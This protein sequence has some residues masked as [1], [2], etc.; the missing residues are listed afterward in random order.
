MNKLWNIGHEAAYHAWLAALA[1]LSCLVFT[2]LSRSD[3]YTVGPGQQ[4]AEPHQIPLLQPGDTVRIIGR[5][6]AN[7]YRS[8]LQ[9]P[10]NDVKILC[11]DG[12]NGRCVFD[13][14]DA[15]EAP[16]VKYWSTQ[17]T[18]QG[19]FTITPSANGQKVKGVTISG[20]KIIG[21]RNAGAGFTDAAG[22]KRGWNF[23]AAGIA[24]YKCADVTITGCAIHDND[25]GIFGTSNAGWGEDGIIRNVT[26][27]WTNF[28]RN[29]V[30]GSD[31]YHNSYI[32]GVNTTYQLCHY[33]PPI[34]GSAGCNLK[35]R[36]AS[37]KIRYC[38]IEGG[39]R[40][41]DLVDPEEGANII[42]QDPLFGRDYVYGNLIINPASGGSATMIHFGFDGLAQNARQKLFYAYNTLVH[43]WPK[44]GATWYAYAFKTN[45]SQEIYAANSIFHGF[46]TDGQ[47][48]SEFRFVAD[49]GARKTFVAMW[50]NYLPSWTTKGDVQPWL[51][52]Q[53]IFGNDPKFVSQSTGDY[54]LQV[55][56][57]CVG[58]ASPAEEILWRNQTLPKWSCD[59]ANWGW[60]ERSGVTDLGCVQFGATPQ[61][62][63]PP[64]TPPTTELA[65]SVV[66]TGI[67]PAAVG[68]WPWGIAVVGKDIVV[69]DH[70]YGGSKVY[71]SNGTAWQQVD[72]GSKLGSV[73]RPLV[74]KDGSLLFRDGQAA[75][76]YRLSGGKYAPVPF[77]YGEG[78]PSLPLVTSTDKGFGHEASYGT[79]LPTGRRWEWNGTNYAVVPYAAPMAAKASQAVKAELTTLY[80]KPANRFLRTWWVDGGAITALAGFASYGGDMFGRY[81]DA[82]GVDQT[83]ALGLPG[84]GTPVLAEDLN[85]DGVKDWLIDGQGLY[86][87]SGG[88][89]LLK[90]GPVTD[91]LKTVG[92]YYK[93][94]FCVDLNSD[95][96]KDLVILNPRGQDTRIYQGLGKGEFKQVEAWWTWDGEPVA[97]ADVNGDGKPDVVLGVNDPKRVLIL[98]TK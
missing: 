53:Q 5:G 72:V 86:L 47:A 14:R 52:D 88:T 67:D 71:R 80:A 79:A 18:A 24:M 13:G 92:A 4:Y 15:I 30:A 16:W 75:S 94:V 87:S 56:S 98:Q 39:A 68:T 85:G 69:T 38:R 34:P 33:H 17:I 29:G 84:S 78:D 40:T 25:N 97:V 1:V 10:C 12:P 65:F 81:L 27:E 2:G 73:F 46:T 76:A 50:A 23:A 60:T 11:E 77:S 93:Q 35:D 7:P 48:P 8:K 63:P 26:V 42:C 90:A 74:L 41:I 3:T 36:G 31:R 59:P 21:A 45:G 62:P 22:V 83:A 49:D 28:Y 91:Q 61:P 70:N 6:E 82:N 43:K 51:W 89:F 37:T 9:I 20:A 54:R 58:K 96:N 95:G 55:R 32:E 57:P 44:Q 64:P 66:D 19:V